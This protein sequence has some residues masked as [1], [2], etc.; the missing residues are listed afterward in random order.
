MVF[1]SPAASIPVLT[2]LP[3]APPIRPPICASI[4]PPA[5]TII[6]LSINPK[7]NEPTNLETNLINQ[8]LRAGGAAFPIASSELA[9]KVSATVRAELILINSI[10]SGPTPISRNSSTVK[11]FPPTASCKLSL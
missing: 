2:V 6:K 3:T 1:P 5:T 10:V 4:A 8:S 7:T 11:V 9:I